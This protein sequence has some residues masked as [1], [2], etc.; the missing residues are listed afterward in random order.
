MVFL[1]DP[2]K[3]SDYTPTPTVDGTELV[4]I[5]KD[6]EN[7]VATVDV[8]LEQPLDLKEDKANKGVADGY[9]SL[10]GG[11]KVP[12]TQLPNAIMEY[13]G[14]WDAA[15]N[16]PT[17]ADGV[18]NTGYVYRVSVQGSQ[19]LGSGV[20]DFEVGDYAIYDG[21]IWQKADTTDAVS[22]VNGRTGDVVVTKADLNLQ[23]VDNTSDLNKPVSTATQDVLDT[24]LEYANIDGG[25]PNS[26]MGGIVPINGGTP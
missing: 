16:S 25:L 21:S 6:G 2:K 19:N 23:N 20:I 5:V 14:L 8:L 10:D 4:P 26:V 22:S 12:V 24:K 15:T 1:L 7:S 13:Q 11:G 3:F 9:A 17:L 18:G